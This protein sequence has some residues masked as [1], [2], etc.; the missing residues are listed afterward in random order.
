[1]TKNNDDLSR[2]L[3]V[4]ASAG[5]G[6]LALAGCGESTNDDGANTGGGTGNNNEGGGENTIE[7]Q[8]WRE[9]PDVEARN[10]D[11]LGDMKVLYTVKKGTAAEPV[12]VNFAH[13]EEP[14]IREYALEV[15]RMFDQLGIPTELD[16]V[17]LNVMYGEYWVGEYGSV[18]PITMNTHGPDPQRGLDPNPLLMRAFG[19]IVQNDFNYWNEEANELLDKQR[20]EIEDQERRIELVREAQSVLSEDV[21]T[22]NTGFIDVITAANTADFEGYV[23]TPGNGTTRDSFVW[24]QVNLQPTGDRSTWV[25]GVTASMGGLNQPYGGGGTEEKR[26]LNIYDGL[27]DASPELEVISGLAT[28]AEVVDE[29]TVE[30]DLREGVTWHDGESFGPEDV[31]FSVEMYQEHISANQAPFIDPIDNVEILSESGGGRIRFNLTRPDAS[32]LTQRAVR[33]VIVPK[34]QWEQ[35]S[36]PDQFN[37]DPPI[38]T[39]PF[40]FVNWQQGERF[41]VE[42][43]DDHWM[44]DEEFREEALGDHFVSGDG[45]EGITWVNVGN[46][47]SLV[48]AMKQ[49]DVDAI[50]T[51]IS[52]GQANNAAQ[53]DG[54]EKQVSKN[55]APLDI[56]INHIYPL[57]RDKEMRKALAYSLDNQ[58]FVDSVLEGRATVQLQCNNLSPLVNP[59]FNPDAMEYEYDPE[60]AKDILTS[61]GYTWG[62]DGTLHWPDGDAWDAYVE[63]LGPENTHKRREELGQP[64]FS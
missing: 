43:W 19:G 26:L 63:R 31:K 51:T 38:G 30:M 50:G 46:V 39:G 22:L 49:G 48:G 40:K 59:W 61:A 20:Q 55:F 1:M 42:R 44:W 37:P 29:T 8:W 34:H 58:G 35:A 6:M 17:P 23:P 7:T 64:D 47:D 27:Y 13:D 32:F 18:V 60:R 14:W 54:I 15:Q 45:I 3:F 57:F 25:K 24:T 5:A 10:N 16:G 33:S 28:G 52:N 4:K 11:N 21:Y 53:A 36:N 41:E 62:D 9:W 56:H 2:R 12:L